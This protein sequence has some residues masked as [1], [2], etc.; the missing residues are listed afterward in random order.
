MH[1]YQHKKEIFDLQDRHIDNDLDLNKNS[2]FN[3]YI[4]DVFFCSLL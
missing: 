4:K 2:F 3:S 1:Q